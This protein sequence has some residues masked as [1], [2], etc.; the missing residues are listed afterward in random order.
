MKIERVAELIRT[1]TEG[2]FQRMLGTKVAALGFFWDEAPLLSS[3]VAIVVCLHGD[4]SGSISL[5][6]TDTQ[7]REFTRRM[8]K[9]PP[10]D[11]TWSLTSVATVRDATSELLNMVA[12]EFRSRL[13]DDLWIEMT[14]PFFILGTAPRF[15]VPGGRGIVAQVDDESGAF[16]VEVTLVDQ[17][18]ES[19]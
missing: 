10:S 6:C 15:R 8:L 16:Q 13:E 11:L 4:I 3:E 1:A 12:G 14:L 5:H 18:A 2:V 9:L 7:A 19:E 17:A